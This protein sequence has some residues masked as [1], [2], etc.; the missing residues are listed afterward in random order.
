MHRIPRQR[1]QGVQREIAAISKT[2][3]I[4]LLKEMAIIYT[5]TYDVLRP[6]K[7]NLDRSCMEYDMSKPITEF[8]CSLPPQNT[9]SRHGNIHNMVQEIKALQTTLDFTENIDE[10]LALE[11]DI[12][13]KILWTCYSG[14]RSA[15]GHIPTKVLHN[16]LENDKMCNLADRVKFLEEISRVFDDALAELPTDDQAHLRRIIADAEVGTSKYQLLLDERTRE[17]RVP[18]ARHEDQTRT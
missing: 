3:G 4:K 11:E 17:Q 14:L 2:L 13:G 5:E 15:V 6:L 16:V 1:M 9:A 12:A 7:G 8:I 18:G 10:Q